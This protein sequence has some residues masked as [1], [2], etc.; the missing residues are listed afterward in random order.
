MSGIDPQLTRA[1][2]VRVQGVEV[3]SPVLTLFGEKWSLTIACP[4]EGEVHKS[5]LSW[6]DDDIEDRAWDLVGEDLVDVRR[7]GSS[8]R[9]QFSTSVLVATPDTDIDPWVL[10]LPD[11]LWVG[12]M[13]EATRT[14][15]VQRN[16][17]PGSTCGQ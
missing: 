3:Q 7:E 6:E 2:P 17:K 14:R 1:L 4:W 13:H 12:R 11:G 5:A 10:R 8:V 9:F 16:S 15:D